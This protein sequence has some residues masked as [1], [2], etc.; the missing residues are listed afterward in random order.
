MPRCKKEGCTVLRSSWGLIEG[1]PQW[2]IRDKPSDAIRTSMSQ[3]KCFSEKCPNFPLYGYADDGWF[4]ACVEHADDT[5]VKLYHRA[6]RRGNGCLGKDCT[7]MWPIYGLPGEQGTYCA[8]CVPKD[9]G[10]ID[11]T[12]RK[13]EKCKKTVPVFNYP[14]QDN[15]VRCGAC[16]EEGM[17]DVM[18]RKCLMCNK[19][20]NHNYPHIKYGEY[21]EEHRLAGMM[22]VNAPVCVDCDPAHPTRACF[23]YP[24]KK[25]QFCIAHAE[26]DMVNITGPQCEKCDTYPTFNYPPNKSGIRCQGHAEPGMTNVV[27]KKC[28][29]GCGQIA[30][31][32]KVHEDY[33]A[34]CFYKENPDH[35]MANNIRI[36]ELAVTDFVKEN[37]PEYNWILNKPILGGKSLRRPD[38]LLRLEDRDIIIEIDEWQHQ[39]TTYTKNFYTDDYNATRLSELLEDLKVSEQK[40]LFMIHFN[41]DSYTL[42]SRKIIPSPWIFQGNGT[43]S[44][45]NTTDWNERLTCLKNTI[46]E[47]II[48]DKDPVQDVYTYYVYFNE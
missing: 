12:N 31:F 19:Q 22:N 16:K 17:V 32:K 20:P 45:G 36:K 35:V 33:C 44:I 3:S 5:M 25:P 7:K 43:L 4:I 8:A 1:Q 38:M 6:L 11:V 34:T 21:C 10:Y 15:G 14:D 27:H 40:P 30:S 42:K 48:R 46:C 26:P 18:N 41:P 28:K 39:G 23:N 37:F 24:G 9:Q 13:C 47:S 2:C 29:A